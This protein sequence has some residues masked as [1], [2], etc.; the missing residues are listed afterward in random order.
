MPLYQPVRNILLLCL[1]AVSLLGACDWSGKPADYR[2]PVE[3]LQ[4]DFDF[5]TNKLDEMVPTIGLYVE[6]EDVQQRWSELRQSIN[7]PMT[8]LELFPILKEA[9]A[10]VEEGHIFISGWG[11]E[12]SHVYQRMLRDGAGFLP[13]QFRVLNDGVYVWQN[14]S[15]V[16]E[17]PQP[18]D[19]L[20]SIN[21]EPAEALLQK[22][23]TQLNVDANIENAKRQDLDLIFRIWYYLL[24]DQPE[25]FILRTKNAAGELQEFRFPALSLQQQSK[26]RELRYGALDRRPALDGTNFYEQEI[27]PEQSALYLNMFTYH[28]SLLLEHEVRPSEFWGAIFARLKADNLNHL[29]I[30]LRENRGGRNEFVWDL[31]PFINK[32]QRQGVFSR[33]TAY[34]GEDHGTKLVFEIPPYDKTEVYSGD[35][36]VLI[37]GNTFS[38]GSMTAM[39]LREFANATLIGSETASRYHGFAASS[40]ESYNL[41]NTDIPVRIPFFV[42]EYPVATAQQQRNQGVVPD[43][44][45]Q[46][47]IEDLINDRDAVKAHAQSLLNQAK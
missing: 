20:V 21:G 41:P 28:S 6:R 8:D 18:G 24:H 26:N 29:V 31:L 43:I 15:D 39:A 46:P 17:A 9:I 47:S 14:R 45:I 42:T 32:N 44:E 1:I 40:W 37:N 19:R 4:E 16:D 5:L 10:A 36:T 13:I 34:D 25:E 23:I 12:D 7:Q 2:Y 22:F 33:A 27:W 35:I 11:D 38:N 3:E 30:D